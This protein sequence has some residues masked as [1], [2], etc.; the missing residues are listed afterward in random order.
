MLPYRCFL[1]TA[2]VSVQPDRVETRF[3][4]DGSIAVAEVDP[5]DADHISASRQAGYGDDQRRMLIE[6]E[7]AHSYV[8]D[9]MS[10]PHS[11]SVWSAAHGSGEKRPMSQWSS[12]VRDEEHLVVSLQA[13]VNTGIEDRYGKLREALGDDLPSV[14]RGFLAVARPWLG[15]VPRPGHRVAWPTLSTA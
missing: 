13:Y 6:H 4:E 12:R 14:A 9:L 7:V 11:W 2:V 15:L 10:W 1:R 5:G 8:A 3:T